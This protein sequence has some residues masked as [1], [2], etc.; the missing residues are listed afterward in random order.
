MKTYNQTI[1]N[2]VQD[3]M[4]NSVFL[5]KKGCY[6]TDYFCRDDNF[7]DPKF[8]SIWSDGGERDRDNLDSFNRYVRRDAIKYLELYPHKI[9][10]FS[11]ENFKPSKKSYS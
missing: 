7:R 11:S 8:Q 5:E 2:L 4:H 9:K 10:E 1:E 6:W 3:V